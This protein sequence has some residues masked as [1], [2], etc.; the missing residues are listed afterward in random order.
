MSHENSGSQGGQ[1][2]YRRSKVHPMDSL[3]AGRA[4]PTRVAS[5]N[6][7]PA[8]QL[9]PISSPT[10]VSGYPAVVRAP[11]GYPGYE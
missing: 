1:D 8:I 3:P 5:Y 2:Q 7:S 4:P 9:V 11:P 6:H 10:R